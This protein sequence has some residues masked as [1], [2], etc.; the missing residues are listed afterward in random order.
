VSPLVPILLLGAGAVASRR[1]RVRRASSSRV[2]IR[3][4]PG[5]TQ[6]RPRIVVVNNCEAWAIPDAW[7]MRVAQPRFAKHVEAGVTSIPDL[8]F[9]LLDGEVGSCPL[10]P[11][12]DVQVD[13][14]TSADY[15]GGPP[16]M[17]YLAQHIAQAVEVGLSDWQR[18]GGTPVLALPPP[19]TEGT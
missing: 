7:W 11:S 5:K 3:Q 19:V 4:P 1:A 18:E 15:W 16:Q 12:L 14:P 13:V 2:Q 8:T 17:L 10:P 9:V 6:M